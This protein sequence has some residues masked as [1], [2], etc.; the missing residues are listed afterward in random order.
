MDRMSEQ[1]IHT[2]EDDDT[3]ALDSHLYS[4]Q[5]VGVRRDLVEA[6]LGAWGRISPTGDP[7]LTLRS[8]DQGAINRVENLARLAAEAVA[9]R[10][11]KP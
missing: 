9:E 1:P 3:P 10:I 6:V 2:I 5:G 4:A 8:V 11:E 7:A